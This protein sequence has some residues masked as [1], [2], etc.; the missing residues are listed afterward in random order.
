[1]HENYAAMTTAGRVSDA[2]RRVFFAAGQRLCREQGAEVV[3]LGG[4]DLFLA[5]QGGAAPASPC[6]I[7]P[8]C[9]WRQ[10]TRRHCGRRDM[11]GARHHGNAIDR[12]RRVCCA[13][14]IQP[15]PTGD[16]STADIT[17]PSVCAGDVTPIFVRSCI[18]GSGAGPALATVG[19]I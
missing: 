16:L 12:G 1:V 4:A 11:R 7:A 8:M 13:G 19:V 14:G 17:N 6:S 18:V 15:M 5:F 10:S 3:L 2:Q 9:T